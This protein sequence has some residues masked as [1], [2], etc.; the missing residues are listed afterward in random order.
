MVKMNSH[1]TVHANVIDSVTG[2]DNIADHWI[3]TFKIY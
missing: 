3:N 1:N 2:Q